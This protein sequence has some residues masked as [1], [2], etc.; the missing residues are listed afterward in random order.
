MVSSNY[1]KKLK[2]QTLKEFWGYPSFRDLQEQII[3]SILGGTDTL[4]LLPTGGGK[5]MCYQL[6]ALITEGTCIVVSPLLALMKDQVEHLKAIG[7]EAEYLSSELN[8]VEE[9]E[10][11]SS[12]K[13]GITKLLYISPERLTN[14]KFLMQIQEV[15]LS[16]MAVDEAHCISEWGQDFRPSYKNIKVFREH[17][18]HI[19]CIALTATATPKVVQEIVQKI[20]L[21]KH[22]VYQKGFKRDNIHIG[23]LEIADKYEKI[24]NY[25]NYNRV[26][27]IIYTN[28]RKEAEEL[29]NFLRYKGLSNVDF[30]H[31]GLSKQDKNIKQKKWS[32]SNF[33]VL[34]STNAFGMGIDKSNVRFV[35][36][37]NPP[38]SIENYYQEIGRAGRDG[39][40]SQAFLLW[41]PQDLVKVDDI[42]KNQIPSKK[43]YQQVIS[44][45]YSMFQIAEHD[46]FED[47]E[48]EFQIQKLVTSTKISAPK[49]K[50]ILEFL[51][52]Q[53]IIYL[54]RKHTASSL[55]L[56]ISYEEIE[57]LPKAD[58]YF[59]ELLLRA[60]TGVAT[61]RVHFNEE[62]VLEKLQME[63]HLFQERMKE[64]KSKGYLDYLDGNN[65]S[66]RFLIPRNERVWL[67]HFYPIFHTIQTNKIRKWEE[68][69]YFIQDTSFCKMKMIL[70]Y[71]GDKNAK[72]CGNCSYC[73]TAN[74]SLNDDKE[75]KK[76]LEALQGNVCTLEQV[77]I[78]I[79]NHDKEQ[80]QEILISLLEE[81]KVRMQDF[82]TYI[83]A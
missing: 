68:M 53:E 18:F 19:P 41:T 1:I 77:C 38:H 63:K 40:E 25:L 64:M 28:T 59:I 22:N 83:L 49:I 4:A 6:P 46:F 60:V 50:S 31:A 30:Y 58:A 27:G 80:V 45:L 17:F 37:Y 72:N 54:K 74:L 20:G 14:K 32:D 5:S 55:E 81:K 21:K 8:S 79:Q 75:K 23:L 2:L 26:S 82:R 66:I 11:Y 16:F 42:L 29:S 10:I 56:H 52:L 62:M 9:D 15:K 47:T 67:H 24:Y 76:I 34:V 13:E 48:W 36:H 73:N 57:Y 43:E 65:A 7:I 51:H 70:R 61:H 71:F 44:T 33:N 69:K 78:L 3:D 35:I 39:L 12:C